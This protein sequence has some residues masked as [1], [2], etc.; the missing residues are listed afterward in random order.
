MF[1][2]EPIKCPFFED[3]ESIWADIPYCVIVYGELT[4]WTLT[5][6]CGKDFHKC[7]AY[8]KTIKKST[9]NNILY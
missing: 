9:E 5:E 4:A 8:I 6:L 3:K 7:P 2:K 1:I